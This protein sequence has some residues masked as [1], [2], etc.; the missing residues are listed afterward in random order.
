MSKFRGL[1]FKIMAN[2]DKSESAHMIILIFWLFILLFIGFCATELVFSI[3]GT[4]S[5]KYRF[6]DKKHRQLPVRIG[7]LKKKGSAVTRTLKSYIMAL[8]KKKS[9]VPISP[10]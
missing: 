8:I 9:Y 3:T 4:F 7:K 1:V 2:G 6:S 10:K 5:K